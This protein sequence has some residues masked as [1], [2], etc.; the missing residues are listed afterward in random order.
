MRLPRTGDIIDLTIDDDRLKRSGRYVLID[1]PKQGEPGAPAKDALFRVANHRGVSFW[2]DK[3]TRCSWKIL[4]QPVTMSEVKLSR[5]EATELLSH[6]RKWSTG[7]SATAD[8]MKK[9]VQTL[10]ADMRAQP[11]FK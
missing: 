6:A 7:P 9:L 5:R 10:V 4:P 8:A 2:V 11:E 3:H 1:P